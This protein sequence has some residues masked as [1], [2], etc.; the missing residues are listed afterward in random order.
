V[1]S[2][3]A[4]INNIHKRAED[5]EKFQYEVQKVVKEK[6][7]SK[8]DPLTQEEVAAFIDE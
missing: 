2:E 6:V 3:D 7:E 4:V 1:S 8:Q 5:V